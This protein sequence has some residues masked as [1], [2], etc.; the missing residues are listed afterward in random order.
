MLDEGQFD[1]IVTG[2]YA[3]ATGA[4]SWNDALTP[5]HEAF[6]T[7]LTVMQSVDL[8]SS[9]LVSIA[10]GGA[11]LDSGVLDYVRH[12]HQVDPRRSVLVANP[13]LMLD[14]WW[15]CHEAFNDSFAARNV[16]YRHFLPAQGSR[17][18]STTASMP[19][20]TMLTSFGLE[21]PAE[22]GILT[23]EERY[24][25]ERIG[26]HA[27]DALK[28]YERLRKMM[29]K[30]LAG[31]GLLES[32][33]YPMWLLDED[34]FVFYKNQ[35][36]TAYRLAEDAV[37][38]PEGRLTWR[39]DRIDRQFGTTLHQ[40]GRGRHGIRAIVDAKEG[41]DSRPRWLHLHTL[42]PGRVLGAFGDRPLVLVTLFDPSQMRELDS[43]A[44][45]D[46]FGTTPT[47]GKIAVL[48]A[49][50]MTAQEIAVRMGS[51]INTIRTHLR[52]V[53]AKLGASRLADAVRLLRQ[54]EALW[55][56][57]FNRTKDFETD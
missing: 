45:G 20:S 23:P 56:M 11:R 42:V 52:K 8:T 37:D 13:S 2:F 14:R 54:G 17:Y 19:S 28:A 40:V 41:G 26:R 1:A 38:W 44:L 9:S 30:T 16:F 27:A 39:S 47:E 32:F 49:E 51:S 35:A 22:R 57:P 48:L 33:S 34:R 25:I 53:M 6:G 24:T 4:Q 36:A 46:I 29:A 55:A 7:R 15:H 5:V 3:A 21:L 50:G 18:M 43:F 10:H 31:H 12:W